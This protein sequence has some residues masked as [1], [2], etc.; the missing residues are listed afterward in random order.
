MIVILPNS[1]DRATMY[2]MYR[3]LPVPVPLARQVLV[4][5]E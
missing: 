4:I 1:N 2:I 5:L 3:A